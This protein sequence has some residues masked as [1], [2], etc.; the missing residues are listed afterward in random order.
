MGLWT[1]RLRSAKDQTVVRQPKTSR[2]IKRALGFAR[3]ERQ[4]NYVLEFAANSE[5]GLLKLSQRRRWLLV[6]F[7]LGLLATALVWF[8]GLRFPYT[9]SVIYSNGLNSNLPSRYSTL[10]SVLLM[11][12][13]FAPPF[14]AAFALGHL[15][16]L[17]PLEPEVAIGVMSTF[18]YRQKSNRRWL[19]VIVAGMFGALNCILLLIA[20]SSATGH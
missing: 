13:P 3:R 8:A 6:A 18:D 20:V 17:A 14:V 15:I 5:V 4:R 12:I 9:A 2:V 7:V 10:I 19:I 16:F 1:S 11:S